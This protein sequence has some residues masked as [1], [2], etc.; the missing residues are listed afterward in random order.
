LDV[1]SQAMTESIDPGSVTIE[2][3]VANRR[4][5][6]VRIKSTRPTT[7]A[8]LFVGRPA[9]DIPALAERLF[10]LCGRSHRL[11]AGRAAAAALDRPVD[12]ARRTADAIG[13]AAERIAILL[14]EALSAARTLMMHG[15]S[16]GKN[17]AIHAPALVARLAEAMRGLGVPPASPDLAPDPGTPI[18]R[19]LRQAEGETAFLA[20]TPDMLTEADDRDVV[21]ALRAHGES[22]AVAPVLPGRV[23]ETGAYAKHWQSTAVAA[24]ALAAR[25]LARLHEMVESLGLLQMAVTTGV[26]PG[27]DPVHSE[28]TGPGEGFAALESPRGRLYHWLRASSDRRISAYAILAPT[29]WNFHPRGPLIEALV[30]AEIGTGEEARRRVSRL[31]AV[32]DPCVSFDVRVQEA[33]NA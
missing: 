10:S 33:A 7:V 21:A 3:A 9:D 15:L 6:T 11:A 32:F 20:R 22:F 18:G 24:T 23:A 8:R 26:P 16:D 14:R 4:V 27:V 1:A 29:E 25:L 17:S 19:L 2:V 28:K 12:Q 13:L 30:G 31:V 5:Q